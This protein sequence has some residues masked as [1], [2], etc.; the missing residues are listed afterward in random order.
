[1]IPQSSQDRGAQTRIKN[2]QQAAQT[3]QIASQKTR[4]QLGAQQ[5]APPHIAAARRA[6]PAPAAGG[7][8]QRSPVATTQPRAASGPQPTG[9]LG[10]FIKKMAAQQQLQ[11]QTMMGQAPLQ[12]PQMDP[13]TQ[14]MGVEEFLQ[15]PALQEAVARTKLTQYF[16]R[17]NPNSVDYATSVLANMDRY[18]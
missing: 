18:Q 2:D 16:K 6:A 17:S 8:Q 13:A 14:Q 4:A 7:Q 3:M 5:Q 11:G 15:S 9:E 12:Q 10:E 1:M